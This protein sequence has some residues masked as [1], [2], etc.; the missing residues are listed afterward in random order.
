MN[1]HLENLIVRYPVLCTCV[2]DIENAINALISLYR[3][4][5]TLYVCGNGGSA[6]DSE[7]ICGELMKGFLLR[8]EL[9]VS[10]QEEF[11]KLFGVAGELLGRRLQCGLRAISLLSHPGLN[12]AFCNDVDPNLC[13]AQ[14]LNALGRQND[15]LLGISTGGGALNVRY[16]MMVAQQKQIK[17]I[18][19]TGSKH[20]ACEKYASI[21]IA[22]PEKE[23]YKIQ[24]LHLP[25]YHA[26]C[27][28]VEES[29][30]GEENGK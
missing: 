18:L 14:Q 26:I 22:V 1:I 21:T 27:L 25:I 24:E 23:T 29:L 3:S 10:E 13:F 2:A 30:F 15:I 28:A 4:D 20:G 19:L 17:T 11:S 16:A 6:A 7:H 9:P 8:R 5:G 12:S